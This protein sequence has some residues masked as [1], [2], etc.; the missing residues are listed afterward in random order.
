MMLSKI[1]GC[2]SSALMQEIQPC[3]L[4]DDNHRSPGSPLF[5]TVVNTKDC[6]KFRELK[7]KVVN[8]TKV[9]GEHSH[10]NLCLGGRA[11]LTRQACQ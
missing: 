2:A 3:A 10:P 4:D 9:V 6:L 5:S 11:H 7:Y 1:A 8:A